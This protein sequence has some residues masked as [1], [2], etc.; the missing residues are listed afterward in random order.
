MENIADALLKLEKVHRYDMLTKTIST[1]ESSLQSKTIVEIENSL[2]S[3]D[4]DTE[5]YNAAVEIKEFV[6]QI[7]VVIHAWGIL[8]ALPHILEPDEQIEY[9]SLGAGNTG[10]R[11]DMATNKRVAE[12]K[13]INWRG[14][15]ESIR[16]NS[17]FKDFYNLVENGDDSHKRYLYVLGT[18]VP[19][20]FLN[21]KR[22]MKSVLSKNN[23]LMA[24]FEAKYPDIEY[25]YQYYNRFKH[26]VE[27]VDITTYIPERN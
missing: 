15:P 5:I 10:K 3:M 12:F 2:A 4:F 11:F 20:K 19:L 17:I 23:K 14:G 8:S 21:N 1:Y 22:K 7:D 9:L 26:L 6:S 25:V 18:E 24:D 16:Q 27:I 13:F